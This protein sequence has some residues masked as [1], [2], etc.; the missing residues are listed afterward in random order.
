M[1]TL[2]F[3]RK[4]YGWGWYPASWEGWLVTALYAGLVIFFGTTIDEHSPTKEVFFTFIIPVTLL[5][6][7]FIRLAYR[8]GEKPKWQWGEKK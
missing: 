7:T 5:T 3:K 8:M 6:I 2:W 1:N 4:T